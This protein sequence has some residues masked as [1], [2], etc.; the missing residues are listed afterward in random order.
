MEWLGAV[1]GGGPQSVQAEKVCANKRVV[2]SMFIAFS[3]Y[4][5]LGLKQGIAWHLT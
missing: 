3:V 1:V 4:E 5:R 2:A